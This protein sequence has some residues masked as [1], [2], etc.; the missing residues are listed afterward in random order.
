MLCAPDIPAEADDIAERPRTDALRLSATDFPYVVVDTAAG[1]DEHTLAAI[2]QLDRPR[3]RLHHG[4]GSVRSLRKELDALD[5]LGM[6]APRRHLVVNRA[7][8]RVGLDVGDVEAVLGM[9]RRPPSPARRPC[10]S[11]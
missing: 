7:D 8:A 5:P 4:R 6:T 1:L 11:R 3:L 9:S 2:E 10:R